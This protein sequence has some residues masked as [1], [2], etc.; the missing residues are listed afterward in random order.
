LIPGAG[1][2]VGA[3][4]GMGFESKIV[5]KPSRICMEIAMEVAEVSDP[6][7]YLV[8]G[9]RLETDVLG[10]IRMGMDS[11][12]VLTGVSQQ[13]DIMKTGIHPTFVVSRLSDLL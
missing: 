7:R 4:R 5:G 12:L 9:D 6:K 10:A 13:K 8:I 11:A 1:C 3:I 2:I